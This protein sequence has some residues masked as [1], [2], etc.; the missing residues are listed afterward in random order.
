VASS[1]TGSAVSFSSIVTT[2]ASSALPSSSVRFS[3]SVTS[4]TST[5][6]MR[7]GLFFRRFWASE[8]TAFSS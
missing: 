1:R 2:A 3:T 8:K 5:P 4:P 7:T 6:E